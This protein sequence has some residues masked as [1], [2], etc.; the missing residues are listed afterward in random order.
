ME[1]AACRR[2]GV[3]RPGPGEVTGQC[4]PSGSEP[5]EEEAPGHRSR[6]AG[7]ASP[8]PHP[9]QRGRKSRAE[10]CAESAPG[11]CPQMPSAASTPLQLCLQPSWCRAAEWGSE[12]AHPL[13]ALGCREQRGHWRAG[14]LLWAGLGRPGR[15]RQGAPR[16]A[17]QSQASLEPHHL[18]LPGSDS[19]SG[20]WERQGLLRPQAS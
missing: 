5:G 6:G 3:R 4:M 12:D 16:L 20:M 10:A 9:C 19:I 17:G 15:P 1:E 2:C 18:R 14:Y 11:A 13:E 8:V 7:V